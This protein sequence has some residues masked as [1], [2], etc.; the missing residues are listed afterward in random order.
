MAGREG[1]LADE[2]MR[3]AEAKQPAA[4]QPKGNA[5]DAW[6]PASKKD[7]FILR[8][9]VSKDFK[10]K[11]RRS[12]LGVAWSVLNPLLMMI[13][14]AIVFTKMMRG[15]DDSIPNF[16]LYLIIG[17]TAFTMMSDSTNAGMSSIISAAPLLKKVKIDRF[18]FPL[19]KVLFSLVNYLFSMIAVVIVMVFYR[20]SPSIYLLWFPVFL[21]YLTVFCIGLSLILAT[22]SV[23]FRDVIHLWG[24][25]LMAWTYAT[26]LFY[27]INILPDWMRA[28]ERFNPMY[29][30]VT[31]VRR[32]LLWRV[33]PGL[34]LNVGCALCAVVALAL[35]VWVFRKNEHKF[36]LYI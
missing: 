34:M 14:M 30:L 9:L 7:R 1:L 4:G 6:Y 20:W 28:A 13:V 35:G 3:E 24:V 25:V 2:E 22:A 36:I 33:S 18:V 17:N 31:Y 23:F 5:A 16:P 10:L 29:L 32:I 27:S 21:V 12:A 26:P 19:Q 8:Q 15:A 11:Y